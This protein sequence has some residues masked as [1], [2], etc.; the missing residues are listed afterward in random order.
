M[1][2]CT[3]A[4]AARS[5]ETAS[6]ARVLRS[7]Q[8][9]CV[10]AAVKQAAQCRRRH[11]VREATS[12]AVAARS[13]MSEQ[14]DMGRSSDAW[15]MTL[16]GLGLGPDIAG[17]TIV[18]WTLL[19]C[20]CAASVYVAR[21]SKADWKERKQRDDQPLIVREPLNARFPRFLTPG[22]LSPM[23]RFPMWMVAYAQL[24]ALGPFDKRVQWT[25]P[26]QGAGWVP[27]ASKICRGLLLS[28]PTGTWGPV[29]RGQD[30]RGSSP[31][32]PWLEAGDETT[33]ERIFWLTVLGFPFLLRWALRQAAGSNHSTLMANSCVE[34]IGACSIPAW[35]VLFM[36]VGGVCPGKEIAIAAVDLS[37]NSTGALGRRPVFSATESINAPRCWQRDGTQTLLMAVVGATWLLPC[38]IFGMM[39]ASRAETLWHAAGRSVYVST[40]AAEKRMDAQSASASG[41]EQVKQTDGEEGDE[42]MGV[43]AHPLDRFPSRGDYAI[44]RVQRLALAT[45]VALALQGA[46]VGPPILV[47]VLTLAV[48]LICLIWWKPYQHKTL[49]Y[50]KS[51]IVLQALIVAATALVDVSAFGNIEPIGV[52]PLQLQLR[53]R[54]GAV[55]FVAVSSLLMWSA[56]AIALGS[57]LFRD[58][59]QRLRMYRQVRTISNAKSALSVIKALSVPRLMPL[60][61]ERRPT[62]ADTTSRPSSSNELE[63]LP[64]RPH[65]PSRGKRNPRVAR[66]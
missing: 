11:W 44:Y 24:L 8:S 10:H 45:V 55:D 50:I 39:F 19:G 30:W 18:V 14:D 60:G 56:A 5:L 51:L 54:E 65:P 27:V 32:G 38:W 33:D 52:E 59:K 16:L 21:H 53:K 35:R 62:E 28:E 47:I 31:I 37:G 61:S 15:M 46:G 42:I 17:V 9:C 1:A 29:E 48:E 40:A 25:A 43:S 66:G 6:L 63:S 12:R 26:V 4:H 13:E 58:Y 57:H 3:C 22:L 20:A 64:S 41:L 34:I 7:R 49:N 36:P 23:V 2:G